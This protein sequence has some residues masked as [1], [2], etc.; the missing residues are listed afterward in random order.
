MQAILVT[1]DDDGW[2]G[3]GG[4][5]DDDGLMIWGRGESKNRTFC[6]RNL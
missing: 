5:V 1:D 4:L 2:E 3:G 6:K